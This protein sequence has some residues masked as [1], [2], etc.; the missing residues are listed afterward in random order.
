MPAFALAAGLVVVTGLVAGLNVSSAVRLKGGPSL[1]LLKLRGEGQLSGQGH[2]RV[3]DRVALVLQ[4]GPHAFALVESV[5]GTG[6]VEQVWPVGEAASGRL[7]A[8]ARTRLKPDFE[9]TSGSVRVWALLSSV[10]LEAGAARRA[11]EAALAESRQVSPLEVEPPRLP[12]ESARVELRLIPE[13]G[14][15]GAPQ[16]APQDAPKGAR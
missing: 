9:V 13:S 12:D 10:P 4:P 2:A 6:H 3:G 14:P 1:Q 15:R 11:F 8:G 5:D 7:E 16:D